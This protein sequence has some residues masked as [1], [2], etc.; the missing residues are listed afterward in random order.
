[1]L[2]ISIV[3]QRIIFIELPQTLAGVA[4]NDNQC[5]SANGMTYQEAVRV[6]DYYQWVWDNTQDGRYCVL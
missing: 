4:Y 5:D 1:M 6:S 3:L 2:Y